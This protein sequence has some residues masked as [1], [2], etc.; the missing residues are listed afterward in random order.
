MEKKL[1]HRFFS[2]F[3]RLHILYHADKEPICGV[4][5]IEELKNHGYN[6]SPG[7]LYPL[8]HHLHQ[9]GY[10]SCK[11]LVISGKRRKNYRVTKSGKKVLRAARA[12]LRELVSEV[13]DDQDPRAKKGILTR[14]R[15]K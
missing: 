15:W 9:V 10:L 4:E 3:V 1:V 2:G 13:L 5:I 12:K 14:S 8:L 11:N 6:L 7:T